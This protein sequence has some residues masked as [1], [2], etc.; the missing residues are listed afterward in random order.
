MKQA[1]TAFSQTINRFI[2]FGM[3]GASGVLVDM[4]MLFLLADP[5]MLGCGLVLSKGLAAETAVI[6]NFIWNDLWTFRDISIKQNTWKKRLGC[7]IK[8]NLIC[9]VGIGLNIL[10]LKSQVYFLHANVYVANLI[11]IFLASLWNFWMNLK[12]GW[13]T[14]VK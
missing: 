11:A 1:N 6:N 13:N 10:L 7:F 4:G 5:R 2:R 12:F 3:V 8:F 14:P 9:L